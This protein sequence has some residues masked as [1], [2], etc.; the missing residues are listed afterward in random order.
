MPPV[1]FLPIDDESL[2]YPY[3]VA[4]KIV[5]AFYLA[6]AYMVPDGYP[7]QDLAASYAVDDPFSVPAVLDFLDDYRI[8][9][10][11]G[12]ICVQGIFI[13]Y[14]CVG[15]SERNP[16]YVVPF[17]ARYDF[18]SVLGVQIFQILLRNS[19]EGTHLFEMQHLADMER[20]NMG[21]H[22][23]GLRHYAVFLVVCHGVEGT[24]K[25]RT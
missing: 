18:M 1:H 10:F 2:A 5:P 14:E 12:F 4:S 11:I 20:V 23:Y 17:I 21:W 7:A 13:V 25:C 22:F 24:H 16:E 6:D 19:C 8:E 9:I 3:V 15:I